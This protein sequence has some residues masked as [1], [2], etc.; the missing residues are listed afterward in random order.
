MQRT[1]VPLM[2]AGAVLCLCL[3]ASVTAQASAQAESPARYIASWSL[4]VPLRLGTN[5][6]FGQKALAPVFTDALGGYVF[7]GKSRF[8]HGVGLGLSLNLTDD[9]G[10]TEPVR[11]LDQLV[12]MPSYLLFYDAAPALFAL[13]H[14]GIP[15][16]VHGG[17]NAGA[18]VAFALGYRL[19]AGI[20]TFAEAGLDA[21]AGSGSTVHV[22]FSLEVG[23]FFDYEVLP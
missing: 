3:P 14:F 19:L 7:S 21:F 12:V 1:L 5:S 22:T 15:F 6:D 16:L 2:L 20:G 4:G 10:Y 13:G 23:L 17:T 11:A 9:G 8:R 18:E